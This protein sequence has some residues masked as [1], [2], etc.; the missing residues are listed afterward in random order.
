LQNWK[1]RKIRLLVAIRC[2]DVGGAEKQVLSFL[3]ALDKGRFEVCLV[4][5]YGGVMEE[6]AKRIQGLT[7]INL[8]KGGRFDVIGF[9]SSYISTINEFSPDVVYSHLSEMN[10]FSQLAR[11]FAKKRYNLAWTLHSAYIDYR[12]YGSF[13]KMVFWLQKVLSKYPEKI[14]CVSHSAYE[15]H[16]EAGFDM[17][18]AVVVYNGVNTIYFEPDETSGD[19]FR[20]LNHI[21]KNML[22]I[23]VAARVDRMKGY[24]LLAEAAKRLLAK[25]PH[26][27]FVAAGDGDETIQEQCIEIL[28]DYSHRFL[29]LGLI[30]ELR[31]F[32]NAINIFCLPS[33]GEAMPLS[34]LEAMSCDRTVVVS[35]VG[36]MGLVVNDRRYVFRSGDVDDL[37]EKLE[38]AIKNPSLRRRRVVD[39]FSIALNVKNTV[40]ELL[41]T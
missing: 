3:K 37:C 27:M 20:T 31:G 13:V 29:W 30:S 10:I 19:A 21:P 32:Y 7:Y 14:I 16:K 5:M 6:N 33:L 22:V 38:Y 36:D 12:S 15:Y 23:G 35:N 4:T 24:P 1:N 2:L 26:L 34:L 9:L 28:G 39:D 25:H 40:L 8:E 41:D 17:D 11:V 18:R